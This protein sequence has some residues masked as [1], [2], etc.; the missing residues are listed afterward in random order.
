MKE[1]KHAEMMARQ[2]IRENDMN[3][4][5]LNLNKML[6]LFHINIIYEYFDN[7]GALLSKHGNRKL[8]IVN[9]SCPYPQQ[10]FHVAHEIGHYVLD[11]KGT[12]FQ[13]V[14]HNNVKKS[15]KEQCADAFA[16]ELLI[17][18][19]KLRK[20]AFYNHFD[21]M[22]LKQIFVVSEYAMAYKLYLLDLPCE[23]TNYKFKKI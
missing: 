6:V 3:S 12:F 20:I 22:K 23:N 16:S 15:L 4:I 2:L 8:M 11:H 9:K 7:F 1:I 21:V 10:R 18:S 14:I 5:P 19:C 17:P 13:S